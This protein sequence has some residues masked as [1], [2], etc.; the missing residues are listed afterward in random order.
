MVDCDSFS[1]Q[2]IVYDLGF[3]GWGIVV[4]ERSGTLLLISKSKS[5]NSH[6][7]TIED[8]KI[9]IRTH[10]LTFWQKFLVNDFFGIEENGY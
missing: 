1:D 2:R 8:S 7:Q 5:K 9:I 4:E 6:P 3:V 10:S